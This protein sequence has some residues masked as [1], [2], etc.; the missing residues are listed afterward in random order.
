MY[1]VGRPEGPVRRLLLVPGRGFGQ[2]GAD[3][4]L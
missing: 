1:Q 4:G 3:V 2:A